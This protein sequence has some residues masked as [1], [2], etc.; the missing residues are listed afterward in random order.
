ML[1][2]LSI[3]LTCCSQTQDSVLQI[4]DSFKEEEQLLSP[5]SRRMRPFNL[6]APRVASSM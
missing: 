4:D 5:D 6:I 1:I 3:L 2:F